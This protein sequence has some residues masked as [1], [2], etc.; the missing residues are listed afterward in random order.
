VKEVIPDVAEEVTTPGFGVEKLLVLFGG[1][2]EVN[3]RPLRYGS[4]GKGAS[5]VPRR[6]RRLGPSI[7]EAASPG[8]GFLSHPGLCPRSEHCG[9]DLLEVVGGSYRLDLR[10]VARN[11]ISRQQV[12]DTVEGVIG[13]APLH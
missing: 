12:P 10:R 7:R 5:A 8:S 13:D 2:V 9:H 4:A 6:P 11:Q 1:E 3:G